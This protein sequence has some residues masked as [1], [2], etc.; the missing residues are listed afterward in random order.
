VGWEIEDERTQAESVA[1]SF[2]RP[3]EHVGLLVLR[4]PDAG[5]R[6]VV[7]P[8]G[9]VI[10][11]EP[12]AAV[13]VRDPNV[14]R[15]HAIIEFNDDRVL[16]TDLGSRNG[17]FINGVQVARAEI[18]DGND[19]QLSNDTVMRVRFQDAVETELLEELQGAAMRDSL[20]GLPNRRYFLDRLRQELA[21]AHRRGEPLGVALI[22]IDDFKKV[23]DVD[24]QQG[25][26]LLLEAIAGVV[27][28]ASR[29]EDVVAR[30][31]HD[32]FAVALRGTGPDQAQ[33]YA[34]RVVSA[35]RDGTYRTGDVPIRATVTVGLSVVPA[36]KKR[37]RTPGP[38][39]NPPPDPAM[40][41]A[42]LDQADQA[43]YRGKHEGKNRIAIW[44]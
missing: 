3:G 16:V 35:V 6:F 42:L 38:A 20:T 10:G 23:L 43:L 21:Y 9:G 26:D 15:R 37:R 41:T 30:Y 25:G 11:R 2:D 7:K 39:E 40:V 1:P 31:G 34:Q 29:V 22:D 32:E 33:R 28:R 44:G 36:G 17:V 4:G 12:G 24:G 18:F 8:P 19:V 5:T 14:S 27:R 13:Q